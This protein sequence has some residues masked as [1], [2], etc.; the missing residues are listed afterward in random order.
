MAEAAGKVEAEVKKLHDKI[1]EIGSTKMKSQQAKL[2]KVNMEVDKA[3]GAITKAKV[4]I[5]NANR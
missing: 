2:D 1:M 4:A 5:K 3:V